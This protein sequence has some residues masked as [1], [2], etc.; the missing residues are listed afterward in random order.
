M[1]TDIYNQQIYTEDEVFNLY[2]QDPERSIRNMFVETV[3]P[4]HEALDIASPGFIKYEPVE[5]TLAEF[6]ERNQNQW[7][8][9]PKYQEMNIA[10]WVLDQCRGEEELQRAGDEL[11]MFAERGMMV[12]LRYLKYLVDTM[13][14]HKIIWGVGR[15][16]SVSSFVLYK[17]GIHRINSIY[18]GLSIDEFLK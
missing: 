11:I 18:Y 8:M 6:D 14:A 1:R 13:R 10:S 5:M 4:I 17:I 9:P 16:S 15:G 3:I 2:M 7:L 12:L